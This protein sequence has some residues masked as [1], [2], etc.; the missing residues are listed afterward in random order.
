VHIKIRKL[1]ATDDGGF[2]GRIEEAYFLSAQGKRHT[3]GGGVFELFTC[4]EQ[5]SQVHEDE[6][7]VLQSFV[8]TAADQAEFAHRALVTLLGMFGPGDSLTWRQ[9]LLEKQLPLLFMSPQRA[10]RNALDAGF[11]HH[12]INIQPATRPAFLDAAS[13]PP[14]RILTAT[15]VK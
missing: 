6:T 8:T 13:G 11:L 4:I 15:I 1:K 2:D 7:H 14:S 12:K 10:A 3:G 5:E 9:V